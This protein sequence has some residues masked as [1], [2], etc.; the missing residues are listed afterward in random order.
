[1]DKSNLYQKH[2]AVKVAAVVPPRWVSEK[3]LANYLGLSVRSLQG[4]RLRNIGPPWR[5]LNGSAVRYDL[6][7]VDSWAA[8]QPGGGAQ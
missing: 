6:A 1:M 4:W 8:Q 3:A 2:P 5:R 7:V